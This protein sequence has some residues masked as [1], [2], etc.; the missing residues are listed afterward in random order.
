[1]HFELLSLQGLTLK[2]GRRIFGPFDIC[3][4]PGERLAILG[5]SGAGKSTLL[6][7]MAGELPAQ[8]GD[9]T[10]KSQAL[11]CWPLSDLSQQRAVL[12]QSHHVAFGLPAALVIGLGRVARVNDP[13]LSRIVNG[14]AELACASHLLG[15]QVDTLSGGE[16]A[17]IQLARVFAQLWDVEDGLVLVD[18][19]LAALDPGLQLQLLDAIG[20]FAAAR[21]H[22]VVAV[23][24]DVNHAL[25][26]F[27][28]LLLVRDGRQID[29]LPSDASA[30]PALESLYGVTF[31]QG[32]SSQGEL[33]VA[34]V[35]SPAPVCQVA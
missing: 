1:M 5:P 2:Q 26:A 8:G 22:A 21:N 9:I 19:P 4:E 6:K 10:L 23:L 16:R 13:A 17:R 33:I 15:R 18:E 32:V 30:L 29:T 35:K 24:H 7:G 20:Q 34:P 27:S 11:A 12:P 28:R 31:A 14:A 3:V 25:Q